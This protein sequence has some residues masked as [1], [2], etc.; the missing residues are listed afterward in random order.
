M[1]NNM[2]T[3]TILAV[4][5]V[6]MLSLSACTL[7]SGISN[8]KE[9]LQEADLCIVD[10]QNAYFAKC[11]EGDA[12]TFSLQLVDA[13][14]RPDGKDYL[15]W[16]EFSQQLGSTFFTRSTV[17]DRMNT[18]LVKIDL[19]NLQW[20][21][22]TF[23]REP[24]V[25]HVG[26]RGIY[27]VSIVNDG[28]TLY[29]YDYDLQLQKKESFSVP[30]ALIVVS[31]LVESE[32]GIYLLCGRIP[33]DAAPNYC[34]NQLW[35][36]DDNLTIQEQIDLNYT[37]GS[38]TGMVKKG[39]LFYLANPVEGV[40]STGE[41]VAKQEI[42]VFDLEQKSF[43]ASLPLTVAYPSKLRYNPHTDTLIVRHSDSRLRY[44]AWT[45]IDLASG[46][47]TVLDYTQL[48]IP[49]EEAATGISIVPQESKYYILYDRYLIIYDHVSKT[50][51]RADLTEMGLQSP[52]GLILLPRLTES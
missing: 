30:D 41:A 33:R 34:E 18:H 32:E 45:L 5:L 3:K 13:P 48:N 40:S 24:Y 50:Y 16:P 11:V 8:V 43:Q 46:E 19:A 9:L 37:Q 29:C 44:Q 28:F 12:D 52:H 21:R 25:F 31:D 17:D 39:P 7:M 22:E 47:Q 42:K 14:S 35:Y 23:E 6:A 27:T 38:L 26:Q 36:L 1:K 49:V 4:F 20:K 10:K 2:K 15:Y 51:V